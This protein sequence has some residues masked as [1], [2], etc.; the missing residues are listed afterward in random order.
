MT[1]TFGKLRNRAPVPY[2]S[3]YDSIGGRFAGGLRTDMTNQLEQMQGISTLFSIVNR[4]SN[5]FANVDWHLYR[6]RQDGRRKTA[7]PDDQPRTEVTSHA[8][9]TVWENPNPFM[10]GM[11]FREAAQQHLDL[12]GET[13]IVVVR[14]P[15]LDIPLELWP[16][17]PDR[18]HPIPH[19][20]DFLT[21]WLYSGPNG[22]QV[23]LGVDD[24]I[25]IKL[26]NPL[27]PYRGLGPVQALLSTLDS[28]RYSAEWNRN[29]FLNSAEPGG[30]VEFSDEL[31]DDEF[32]K[33][34]KRWRDSHQGVNNAHRVAVLENGLKWVDRSYSQRD[35]QFAEL[36]N[37]SREMIREGFGIHSHMLGLTEDVNRANADA[38]EVSFA[39]WLTS[40]R[41]GRWQDMLNHRFLPMFKGTGDGVEFEHDRVVPEDREADD[42]ERTSKA[43]AAAALANTGVWEPDDILQAVGL[44]EMTAIP[45][46]QRQ[47]P[48]APAPTPPAPG[49]PAA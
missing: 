21:G 41:A 16:V 36:Q 31:D 46:E 29:F 18:M 7:M 25:Q 38:G 42:R 5:A 19:P 37:I 24:V 32:E 2:V 14:A 44:P 35:M 47:P 33:F 3:R 39:R 23:P 4:T 22:E 9:L 10:T 26:P 11:F 8:A 17:R 28:A 1:S 6:K 27:D 12:V 20:T 43:N 48:K 34:Q 49:A 30:V 45:I 13:D 40:P 15:G